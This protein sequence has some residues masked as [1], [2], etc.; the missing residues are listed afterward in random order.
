MKNTMKT[1][2]A[3]ALI[4]AT[5]AAQAEVSANIAAVSDYIFRGVSQT[6]KAAVQGGLDF[7][8]E[9]GLY[10]GTWMSNVNFG[11][12]QEVDL[13][14]G[15]GAEA[16]G[17][18]YDVNV[19]YY[20][21]PDSGGDQT[22]SELDYAEVTGG[23]SFGPA[24]VSVSYTVWGE[25]SNAPFDNGDIYYKAGLDVPVAGMLGSDF[26]SNVFIGYYDFD[27]K[28]VSNPAPG[29][30]VTSSESYLHWGASLAKDV[31]QLGAV[32]VN[33]EQTD[34][35][36]ND[37]NTIAAADGPKIWIGWSKEF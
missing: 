4:A 8:D 10:A 11:G 27:E 14:A 21:Y 13:Y 28:V 33:Y 7:S 31:G 3:S 25:T 15:F 26:S 23:L 18:G 37:G 34:G 22:G 9:S 19:L 20:W 30:F 32:S 16:N 2:L 35:D 17:I 5:G 24:S 29:Q 1:V 36:S 12:G 6:S